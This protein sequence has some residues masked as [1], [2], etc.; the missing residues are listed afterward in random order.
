MCYLA[1]VPFA[2]LGPHIH[3]QGL[4][5]CYLPI[6]TVATSFRGVRGSQVP[7]CNEETNFPLHSR[8]HGLKQQG[9]LPRVSQSHSVAALTHSPGSL[10]N[11]SLRGGLEIQDRLSSQRGLSCALSG[12]GTL[13]NKHQC[14]T[15]QLS[16]LHLAPKTKFSMPINPRHIY[17]RNNYNHY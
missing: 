13:K 2:L 16:F 17:A 1:I 3:A 14:T 6:F 5:V 10:V 4:L 12:M 8:T 7:C 11:T 9:L 15:S